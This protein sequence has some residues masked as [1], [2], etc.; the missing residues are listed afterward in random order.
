MVVILSWAFLIAFTFASNPALV[1]PI[2]NVHGWGNE[3]DTRALYTV[4]DPNAK[5]ADLHMRPWCMC[6][7][8]EPYCEGDECQLTWAIPSAESFIEFALVSKPTI[9]SLINASAQSAALMDGYPPA[10]GDCKCYSGLP[11]TPHIATS[12]R[13]YQVLHSHMRNKLRPLRALTCKR[14]APFGI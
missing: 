7:P 1:K 14:S 5:L 11:T 9:S 2:E 12:I 8:N 3:T 6:P 4:C 13:R 10:C